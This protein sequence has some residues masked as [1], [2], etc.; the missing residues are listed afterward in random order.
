MAVP[1]SAAALSPRPPQG[2]CAKSGRPGAAVRRPPSSLTAPTRVPAVLWNGVV[3]T[4]GGDSGAAAP[5]VRY[6]AVDEAPTRRHGWVEA[7][8]GGVTPTPRTGH[9]LCIAG[10]S[11]LL[12]YGG[13]CSDSAEP[14][15]DLYCLPLHSGRREWY[16]L[17]V[18]G[19]PTPLEQHGSA[20][21]E[22][23]LLFAGGRLRD[24][25]LN[26]S[27]FELP[28]S[29]QHWRRLECPAPPDCCGL[30]GAVTDTSASAL[31]MY[32]GV[33]A[34]GVSRGTL[35][36]LS[37]AALEW[38]VVV[39]CDPA[40]WV[41]EYP[42]VWSAEREEL[43]WAAPT[44][45]V[46][47]DGEWTQCD[48]NEG[49]APLRVTA[50]AVVARG[51]ET[52]WVC[53]TGADGGEVHCFG[54]GGGKWL[55]VG[56]AARF[57]FL[58]QMSSK[59]AAA[60]SA[61]SRAGRSSPAR[62]SPQRSAASPLPPLPP[63]SSRRARGGSARLHRVAL[64]GI[65]QKAASAAPSGVL[66]PKRLADMLRRLTASAGPSVLQ[67]ANSGLDTGD[68]Y[69]LAA[70]LSDAQQHDRFLNVDLSGNPPVADVAAR[71]L[72]EAVSVNRRIIGIDFGATQINGPL[73]KRI[74]SGVQHNRRMAEEAAARRREKWLRRERV[75]VQQRARLLREWEWGRH[76]DRLAVQH[77]Y[78]LGWLVL[79]EVRARGM[80]ELSWLH[81]W[82]AAAVLRRA[83]MTRIECRRRLLLELLSNRAAFEGKAMDT[84]RHVEMEEDRRLL[85]LRSVMRQERKEAEM[86]SKERLRRERAERDAVQSEEKADRAAVREEE[87]TVYGQERRNW[88]DVLR[89]LEHA[90]RQHLQ[91]LAEQER[92]KVR[93]EE[94]KR[95]EE[96]RL[97]A[98]KERWVESRRKAQ[99]Q[100]YK[101]ENSVRFS[102]SS[103]AQDSRRTIQD[104]FRRELPRAKWA[105]KV[106]NA[107]RD[108]A[109]LNWQ[110]PT[111]AIQSV[112]DSWDGQLRIASSACSPGC[113]FGEHA[114]LTASIVVPR[115]LTAGEKFDDDAET[116]EEW[117][118]RKG[119][120]LGGTL[121]AFVDPAACHLPMISVDVA[122][123]PAELNLHVHR[124]ERKDGRERCAPL[125]WSEDG[126]VAT[127]A[128]VV[129]R[130]QA[131]EAWALSTGRPATQCPEHVS[132]DDGECGIEIELLE[133]CTLAAAG[134]ILRCITVGTER[135]PPQP[136]LTLAVRLSLDF[137]APVEGPDGNREF[138]SSLEG[139]RVTSELVSTWPAATVSPMLQV[140]APQLT[141]TYHEGD[142]GQPV[143]RGVTLYPPPG[144]RAIEGV[145]DGYQLTV[146]FFARRMEEDSLYY[147]LRLEGMD[148][149]GRLVVD[150]KVLG[151]VEER[152]CV[153]APEDIDAQ[154]A[155]QEMV[156]LVRQ[157]PP[158]PPR[159]VRFAAKLG[160]SSTTQA[161]AAFIERLEYINSSEAPAEVT[162]YIEAA[163]IG[164]D[165]HSSSI[166][167]SI[168]VIGEDDP[169]VIDFGNDMSMY[170][171]H[172]GD[173][174]EGLIREPQPPLLIAVQGSV[175]DVDTEEFNTGW[176]TVT[177]TAGL[178]RGDRILLSP[179][180][181]S[182]V[183]VVDGEILLD[184]DV[185]GTIEEPDS[186]PQGLRVVFREGAGAISKVDALFK[187]VAFI[188]DDPPAL[189]EG[190]RTVEAS[191][192]TDDREPVFARCIVKVTPPLVT[193]PVD[194]Q[195]VTFK[196]DSPMQ[197]IAPFELNSQDDGWDGG[198]VFAEF[199]EGNTDSD[200]I[201]LR[202]CDPPPPPKSSR[203]APSPAPAEL[204]LG[205]ERAVDAAKDPWLTAAGAVDPPDDLSV[206]SD[207]EPSLSPLPGPASPVEMRRKGSHLSG[208]Q[209]EEIASPSVKDRV[210]DRARH[211]AKMQAAQRLE[212]MAEIRQAVLTEL[213]GRETKMPGV[214]RD[215]TFGGK[216][217]GTLTTTDAGLII[218]FA[219]SPQL[220]KAKAAKSPVPRVDLCT[221]KRKD[222]ANILSSL[223]YRNT[224]DDPAFVRKVLRVVV[225]DGLAH[226]SASYL[227]V[228]VQPVNDVT[229]IVRPHQDT[230]MYRQGVGD[231]GGAPLFQ[232]CWLRDPDTFVFNGGSLSVEPLGGGDPAGDQLCIMSA[233]RQ[234]KLLERDARH[235]RAADAHSPSLVGN[236]SS[237]M[238]EGPTSPVLSPRLRTRSS[239]GATSRASFRAVS[240]TLEITS[241]SRRMSNLA[242]RVQ[243]QS[244]GDSTPVQ[245]TTDVRIAAMK[246]ERLQ[247]RRERQ[248]AESKAQ[249]ANLSAR[250]LEQAKDADQRLL[251]HPDP[252][253]Q[254]LWL[255][256]GRD[257]QRLP[258]GRYQLDNPASGGMSTLRIDFAQLPEPEPQMRVDGD[259]VCR[260]HEQFL[261]L[262]GGDLGSR[263]WL[264]AP[265]CLDEVRRDPSGDFRT[266]AGFVASLDG[267]AEAAWEA[268]LESRRLLGAFKCADGEDS[269]LRSGPRGTAQ[270]GRRGGRRRGE[271]PRRNHA[272]VRDVPGAITI[273][274]VEA[275]LW[276]VGYCNVAAKVKSY[277]V[278]YQ[279]RVCAGDGGPDGRI[280]LSA[281][282][283]PAFLWAPESSREIVYKENA[284][285][286]T[287]NPHV[288]ADLEGSGDINEGFLTCSI[289]DGADESDELRWDF[290]GT[291][292]SHRDST[293]QFEKEFVG[294]TETTRQSL[295]VDWH[296]HS[297]IDAAVIS[298]LI[299]C[300]QFRNNSDDP[301]P[302]PRRIEMAFSDSEAVDAVSK[303]SHELVVLADDDMTEVDLH[304]EQQPV[305][306][307]LCSEPIR[308][309]PCAELSDPDSEFFIS[310]TDVT[311]F[312][313][314]AV[315][316][317]V[318]Q[319][320]C[321]L[322][323]AHGV[324]WEGEWES[325]AAVLLD[326]ERVGE[327]DVI[328]PAAFRVSFERCSL[329]GVERLLRA[330]TYRN[331]A[332]RQR[333]SRRLVQV[334][335][336]GGEAPATQIA[337]NLE[338][339]PAFLD[340]CI[341][342]PVT[343][344]RL[345]D[346]Q[347]A[348]LEKARVTAK[349]LPGATLT[350]S[351]AH[352]GVVF[353]V[354]KTG[355]VAVR[356]AGD[357]RTVVLDGK[358][359]AAH[360]TVT[361]S[362]AS[363]VL[364]FVKDRRAVSATSLSRVLRAVVLELPKSETERL[365][366]KQSL[367]PIAVEVRLHD[368][369]SGVTQ[370]S[371]IE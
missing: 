69:L 284:G 12:V 11:K 50:A 159:T 311:T 307:M 293:L 305:Q 264:A 100:V 98:E 266:Y 246:R 15:N 199:V 327:V 63:R 222:V 129:R 76:K 277:N 301:S 96:E 187:C 103:E 64:S 72:L 172:C 70:V 369:S 347:L 176:L 27:V 132:D 195:L 48:G 224:S 361:E 228:V 183:R 59:R 90:H 46:A 225:C 38:T 189:R 57:G 204:M 245:R 320:Q 335:V 36:S 238:S 208:V 153:F 371:L 273:E 370:T 235:I 35:C 113:I 33:C 114:E 3:V 328:S 274:M 62:E 55:P 358:T 130:L 325:G 8:A 178:C 281:S 119:R 77:R 45:A 95:I 87:Q 259:G 135:L 334:K 278:L 333:N 279:V 145:L 304:L 330:A 331:T 292:F 17:H 14:L 21:A 363:L 312:L 332:L 112:A 152:E 54:T 356:T 179:P 296:W 155:R 221:V 108:R 352:P 151:V 117:R 288:T 125:L 237:P 192:V 351:C 364:Q 229:E 299:H 167:V 71:Q 233:E 60:K 84:R 142:M 6:L 10:G 37:L 61:G 261:E 123:K 209:A 9:S 83:D 181:A 40:D 124:A 254:S 75:R 340:L 324:D 252:S 170:R 354:A 149:E 185:L 302:T 169:T 308:L 146:T 258:L 257:P 337:A 131:R 241:P 106:G 315:P 136:T 297:H 193:V 31:L 18:D 26:R 355:G 285:W 249:V 276:A 16:R 272:S 4:V 104:V 212:R 140:P 92:E 186:H 184:G 29:T 163:V 255:Q 93:A 341:V 239:K 343:P 309:F 262:H 107:R 79:V 362:P 306:Y 329:S 78:A 271:D 58:P 294:Y 81:D 115:H 290:R 2:R 191:L 243:G 32:G 122:P 88:K 344:K 359:R 65:A 89:R 109:K 319:E 23:A 80:E 342:L 298:G 49:A 144:R 345:A 240:A 231:N 133:G 368:P 68:Y 20:A 126:K 360:L 44:P 200:I 174:M 206:T 300:I 287:I 286:V 97:Q 268:G 164:P 116:A 357:D 349:E 265:I 101:D 366:R 105:E 28:Y 175:T 250:R 13:L 168:G 56:T 139:G 52:C 339:L 310:T 317:P 217:L 205:A 280:R 94:R 218:N 24:G 353:G 219:V 161:V 283:R 267:G 165:G 316:K 207:A 323:R 248:V 22:N 338:L 19:D 234:N 43:W 188:T 111:L 39:R 190:S 291:P 99:L 7:A 232:D 156:P 85:H 201:Q 182:P 30:V 148:E 256:V 227:E 67:L 73:Q 66:G 214:T 215:L 260:V 346:G 321:M 1:A 253:D 326:G 118:A 47:R 110:P 5:T 203:T 202:A 194:S 128:R 177:V 141:L 244:A 198:F 150:G 322:D 34:D 216:Q 143:F 160:P 247:R 282:V 86:V 350:L 154:T 365:P 53:C 157:P 263:L 295:R 210:R 275:A 314:V 102:L 303:L 171:Q 367:V 336:R 127:A 289:V 91:A 51:P 230:F 173:L 318:G 162:R 251:V 137:V 121:I 213:R 166:T 120:V 134:G 25:S 211:R 42:L 74:E 348:F 236:P 196:E 147:P 82:H 197:R 313:Q 269:P 223:M 220:S 138:P 270:G 226:S 158:E 242:Q 180:E 41:P